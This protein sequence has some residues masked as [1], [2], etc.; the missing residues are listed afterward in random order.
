MLLL[1]VL[2]FDTLVSR[3]LTWF[4]ADQSVFALLIVLQSNG[5]QEAQLTV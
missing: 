4:D 1:L 2:P 3:A 5:D